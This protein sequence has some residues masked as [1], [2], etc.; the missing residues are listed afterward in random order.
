V[1]NLKLE[2]ELL[3]VFS[4]SCEHPEMEQQ[5]F[6]QFLSGMELCSWQDTDSFEAKYFDS[7][8]DLDLP[9]EYLRAI[10]LT[11]RELEESDSVTYFQLLWNIRG[12]F[13]VVD[14]G[15]IEEFASANFYL[16]FTSIVPGVV[17][18]G[19]DY[20]D[21]VVLKAISVTSKD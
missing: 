6:R 10:S 12:V 15:K 4:L 8:S 18:L 7:S 2:I 17:L 5:L 14:P 3:S 11:K 16:D 19:E 13:F 9:N 1:S 21:G 20:N